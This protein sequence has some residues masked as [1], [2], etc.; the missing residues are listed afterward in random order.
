RAYIMWSRLITPDGV[1]IAL[2]SPTTDFSG[3]TGVAGDVNTHFF[4]RFGSAILMS[5]VDLFSAIGNASVVIS[6]G[7]NAASVA[8]QRDS[9]IPPTITVP[10]GTPIRVFTARDLD[11]STVDASEVAKK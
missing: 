4:A 7:S 3:K 11:F 10:Q 2:A 6:G 9:Q 8:A 5:V 1:S